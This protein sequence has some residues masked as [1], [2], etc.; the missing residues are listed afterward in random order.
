[1]YNTLVEKKI[2]IKPIHRNGVVNKD[3]DGYFNGAKTKLSVPLTRSGALVDPFQ[4]VDE[5][6]IGI[7][8]EKL[9]MKPADF[10]VNKKENNFWKNEYGEFKGT[11]DYKKG[12]EIP[13]DRT[14]R[15]L[16]L[17]NPIDFIEYRVL[18]A[19]KEVIAPSLA[20]EKNKGSYKWA[21]VDMDEEVTLKVKSSDKKKD[22]YKEFG[23]MEASD[24]KLRNFLR[25]YGR[26]VAKNATKDW[27]IGEVD[28]IIENEIDNFLTIV[29]DADYENRLFILDAV[30][31]KAINKTGADEYSLLGGAKMGKYGTMKEAIAFIKDPKNQPEV[32]TI[33]ARIEAKE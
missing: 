10:N 4:G 26:T 23:K 15:I 12:I 18:L 1:M 8:A 30:N 7:I 33:K 31:A 14:E 27:M 19:N 5:A 6:T 17:S 29:K 9:A 25:V 22:A 20:E 16:D 32:L 28:G 3:I 24:T 2:K 21:L 13:L 11:I